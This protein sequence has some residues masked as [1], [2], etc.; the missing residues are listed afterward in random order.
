MDWC[1]EPEL[2]CWGLELGELS[3]GPQVV[4]T[5]DRTRRGLFL[6]WFLAGQAATVRGI[7]F[8]RSRLADRGAMD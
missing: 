1:N 8:S 5:Q 7:R 2:W 3:A 4:E 6:W